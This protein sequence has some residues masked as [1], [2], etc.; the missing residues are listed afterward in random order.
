MTAADDSQ[1]FA[2][3]YGLFKTVAGGEAKQV[4]EMSVANAR[5]A[6]LISDAKGV[7]RIFCWVEL[8]PIVR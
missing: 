8:L 6:C 5:P 3:S 7:A 2:S 4:L 1:W